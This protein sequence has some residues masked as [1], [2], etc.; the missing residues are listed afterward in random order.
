LRTWECRHWKP[1]VVKQATHSRWQHHL[2]KVVVSLWQ[3]SRL[4]LWGKY[5]SL[6][7]G[8]GTEHSVDHWWKWWSWHVQWDIIAQYSHNKPI[9]K[10]HCDGTGQP[11]PKANMAES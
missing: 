3:L 5:H 6:V 10:H 4:V 9:T 2:A 1:Q 7:T 11:M 8:R